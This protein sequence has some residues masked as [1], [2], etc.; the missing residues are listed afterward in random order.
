MDVEVQGVAVAVRGAAVGGRRTCCCTWWT[1]RTPTWRSRSRRWRRFWTIWALRPSR[2]WWRSTRSTGSTAADPDA[3][4]LQAQAL[5][6]NPQAVLISAAHGAGLEHLLAAVDAALRERM[7]RVDALIP[8]SRG[9]LVAMLHAH[10]T[11]EDGDAHRARHAPRRAAAGGTGGAAGAILDGELRQSSRCD[12]K[13]W[14][15]FQGASRTNSWKM[16]NRQ[17]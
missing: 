1:S 14:E 3:A 6:D 4:Q 7:A 5:A 15:I 16:A 13:G 9:D 10:G 17:L 12:G 11:V 8:Y 2:P